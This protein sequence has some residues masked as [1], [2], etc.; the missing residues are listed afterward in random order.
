M[1]SW[2]GELWHE[3]RQLVR[4]GVST[5]PIGLLAPQGLLP[6]R[7]LRLRL[8]S[9]RLALLAHDGRSFQGDLKQAAEWLERYFDTRA[10]VV[11]EAQAALQE[12]G[13]LNVMRTPA[14][15]NETLSAL[16]NFKLSRDRGDRSAAR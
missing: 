2:L 5:A 9:A 6:A 14:E 10:P 1:L 16:R 7:N 4:I 8:L 15:L 13:R 3:V 11:Q 12:L